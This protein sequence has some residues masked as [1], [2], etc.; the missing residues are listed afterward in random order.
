MI[1]GCFTGRRKMGRKGNIDRLLQDGA[2]MVHDGDEMSFYR[3]SSVL[4][5]S[6]ILEEAIEYMGTLFSLFR[7]DTLETFPELL[8]EVLGEDIF[9]GRTQ[10]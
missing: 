5:E 1:Q 4:R 9:D 6:K 2:Y 7:K 8:H 10:K 3:M